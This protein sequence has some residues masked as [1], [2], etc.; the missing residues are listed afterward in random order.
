MVR[1][2]AF[3]E[4]VVLISFNLACI[5]VNRKRD[6]MGRLSLHQLE[7][8]YWTFE[9]HLHDIMADTQNRAYKE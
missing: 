3:G 6:K 2:N 7:I 5:L 1:L 4:G 8:E 9:Y